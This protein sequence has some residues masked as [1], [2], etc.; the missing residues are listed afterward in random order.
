[1]SREKGGQRQLVAKELIVVQSF[2]NLLGNVVGLGTHIF[3][4]FFL[5]QMPDILLAYT[6]HMN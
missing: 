3:F 5:I 2:P 4:F 1:M 6:K